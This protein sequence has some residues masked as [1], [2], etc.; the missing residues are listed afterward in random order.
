MQYQLEDQILLL[1]FPGVPVV[2]AGWVEY[3]VIHGAGSIVDPFCEVAMM[4]NDALLGYLLPCQLLF[5]DNTQ[6]GIGDLHINVQV[7]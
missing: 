6:I 5:D 1:Q 2:G 4:K 3:P 7:H